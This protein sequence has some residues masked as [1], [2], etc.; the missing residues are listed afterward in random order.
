MNEDEML[1]CIEKVIEFRFDI[2]DFE[3]R[4]SDA[5]WEKA[6]NREDKARH[7]LIVSKPELDKIVTGAE[8][9]NK[10]CRVKIFDVNKLKE[11]R[12]NIYD[13]PIDDIVKEWEQSKDIWIH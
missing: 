4:L 5:L 11:I 7:I 6:K 3:E 13:A 8:K 2:E 10:A 12:A 1:D 9:V